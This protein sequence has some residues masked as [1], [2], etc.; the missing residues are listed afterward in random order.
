M[1]RTDDVFSVRDDVLLLPRPYSSLP[2]PADSF[3]GSSAGHCVQ[4][5]VVQYCDTSFR[6]L[7]FVLHCLRSPHQ[8]STLRTVRRLFLRDVPICISNSAASRSIFW[9]GTHSV[10]LVLGRF[11]IEFV[12][13]DLE[14]ALR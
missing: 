2:K 9:H 13:R 12:V 4:A 14:L 10:Q 1:D 6:L 7:C 8:A 5:A 3:F 11:S